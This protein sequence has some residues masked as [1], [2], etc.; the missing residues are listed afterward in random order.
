[1]AITSEI[2]IVIDHYT[3]ENY[4]EP[5]YLILSEK[6]YNALYVWCVEV[7]RGSS[8]AHDLVEAQEF[9]GL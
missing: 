3:T 5:T 6:S 8:Q 2:R 1:M 9:I 7:H 4:K